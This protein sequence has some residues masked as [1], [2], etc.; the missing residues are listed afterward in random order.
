MKI[1]IA[2]PMAGWS[3]G[4]CHHASMW[5]LMRA[6][7]DGSTHEFDIISPRLMVGVDL[8][9]ARSRCVRMFLESNADSLLFVDSDVECNITAL[10]GMIAEDVELIGAAYPKKRRD[11][12]GPCKEFAL[13][14]GNQSCP[15][16]GHK[17]S[18]D[19]IGM[20]FVL[21]KRPLLERMVA[22]YDAELGADDD[23]YRTTMLFMLSFGMNGPK[24]VLWPEDYSFCQRVRNYT[25]VWLYTGPG[26]PL[27]H[28]GHHLYQGKAE[29]VHPRN[30]PDI[31]YENEW[32]EP[33]F[34]DQADGAP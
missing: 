18:I 34:D 7:K 32:F 12:Y 10:R 21:I 11:E 4:G 5:P 30:V 22:D 28:E 27:G 15:I 19:A 13:H 1:L 31:W 33:G 26:A 3:V 16:S 25:R 17:A 8:V 24:R 29:H 23:G 2:T 20:G 9:R 14:T 6:A